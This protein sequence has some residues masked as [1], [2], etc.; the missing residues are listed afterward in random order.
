MPGATAMRFAITRG[1]QLPKLSQGTVPYKNAVTSITL[2]PLCPPSGIIRTLLNLC[3]ASVKSVLPPVVT[4]FARNVGPL[5][6]L[7]LSGSD[8]PPGSLRH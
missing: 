8:I 2:Y 5:T 3:T 1:H 7:L 4:L 6:L